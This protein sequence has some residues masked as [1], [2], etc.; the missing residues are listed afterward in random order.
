MAAHMQE[1]LAQ[2]VAPLLAQFAQ[3]T[4]G[5]EPNQIN[6]SIEKSIPAVLAGVLNHV[7]DEHAAKRFFNLLTGTNVDAQW[8]EAGAL[9]GAS[10]DKVLT[11]G[12]QWSGLLFG[13]RSE[14]VNAAVA[15]DAGLD[16]TQ[17]A[18]I[19]ALAVPAVLAALKKWIQSNQYG[20][21]QF[22]GQ[23]LGQESF[24]SKIFS[25]KLLAALGVP[26]AL[27]LTAGVRSWGD[28]YF[29]EKSA[30]EAPTQTNSKPA[31]AA[32]HNSA[33]STP[34]SASEQASGMGWAKWVLG[35]IVVGVLGWLAQSVFL[36]DGSSAPAPASMPVA[37]SAPVASSAV[38]AASVPAA[39]DAS[40]AVT[41][42]EAS[43]PSSANAPEAAAAASESDKVVFE[44]GALKFYFATGSAK[45]AA[46]AKELAAE[47]LAAAKEGKKL[48]ISGY[49]DKTGDAE[50]NEWLAKKRAQAV[51]TFLRNQGVSAKQIELVKPEQ[52]T[53]NSGNMAEDRRV[54]VTV[55]EP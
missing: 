3:N 35:L 50:S 45:V 27:A 25:P 48:R 53:S 54:E 12:K 43:A 18:Q 23:L 28:Q 22:Y 29:G 14:E 33:A 5:L 42:S 38:V 37:A 52:N 8:L 4:L 19:M 13:N 31:A 44:N 32:A 20:Q 30:G 16:S 24:F 21:Y 11:L 55:I 34:A 47:I 46:D 7:S 49:N 15:Q 17:S 9:N 40:A 10:L 36:A 26:S 2:Y 1:V 6:K 51:R 39:S 41:A